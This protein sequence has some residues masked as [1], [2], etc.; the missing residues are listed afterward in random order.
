MKSDARTA[1]QVGAALRRIRIG[2]G[3]YQTKLAELAGVSRPMLCRYER[4][5]VCPS[6]PSL[7]KLLQALD[8]DAETFGR[9]LGPWG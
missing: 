4:G 6:V 8:C 7:V 1:R 3:V 9:H 5:H 2:R